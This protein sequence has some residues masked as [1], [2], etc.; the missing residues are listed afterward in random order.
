LEEIR[1]GGHG[2]NRTPVRIHSSTHV[3]LLV[4]MKATFFKIAAGSTYSAQA[5]ELCE[6]VFK[7][8]EESKA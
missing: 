3:A 8:L 7:M 4:T 5:K 1:R 2:G 6:W